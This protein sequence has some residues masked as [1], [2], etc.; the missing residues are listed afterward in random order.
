[1]DRKKIRE[2]GLLEKYVL[3]S[4]TEQETVLL[5]AALSEDAE[6][7]KELS[8]LE[9]E[10]ELIGFEN[11]VQ[12][13]NQV[14]EQL[15]AKM[16]VQSGAPEDQVKPLAGSSSS[17]Q[18]GKL[19]IAASL[20]ALFALGSFW[21]YIQWQSSL[22]DFRSLE[23]QT[24]ELQER[25]N[26]LESSFSTTEERY[27]SISSPDVI[28]LYLK[29]NEISPQSSMI[30]YINHENK[31]VIVNTLGLQRLE[32]DQSYQLWADVD[33]EM[34][35]M[36]ILPQDEEYIPVRYIDKAESLNITIEP[37]GGSDHPTVE[38][39]ISNIYL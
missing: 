4:L 18:S 20:A 21:L 1:M 29:G 6:L 25:L 11:A 8:E 38:N 7:R 23:Q 36:G 10:F 3:G 2:E 37:V 32:A 33:G 17:L 30:A 22:E 26:D 39:L 5:E 19:L 28:P 35:N 13:S 12:P 27:V 14:K 34:I 16:G 15:M 9:A 24:V 31:S